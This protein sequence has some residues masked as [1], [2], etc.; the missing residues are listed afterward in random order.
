MA[1]SY[2][3]AEGSREVVVVVVPPAASAVVSLSA[4]G[5]VPHLDEVGIPG[6]HS[7]KDELFGAGEGVLDCGQQFL[8]AVPVQAIGVG[9]QPQ[10]RR[11]VSR[12]PSEA[13]LVEVVVD[14]HTQRARQAR[15]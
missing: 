13:G 4:T 14:R 11:S 3:S 15:S 1:K 10:P 6:F 2:W 5:V 12:A 9:Y 7:A 8:P